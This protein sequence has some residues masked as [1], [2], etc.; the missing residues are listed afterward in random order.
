[1]KSAQIEAAWRTLATAAGRQPGAYTLSGEW[2]KTDARRDHVVRRY[3]GAHEAV[4]FKM[5]GKPADAKLFQ[6]LLEA[7]VRAAEGMAGADQSVPEV[8]EADLEARAFLMRAVAGRTVYDLLER[9][10]DPAECL[11]RGGRWIAAFHRAT[12]AETR[13]FQPKFMRNHIAHLL[14]QQAKGEISIA[15]PAAFRRHAE[16][17]IALAGQFEGRKTASA[18]THGDMNLRN[19]LLDGPR[20][21]GIDFSASH[22]APVGFDVARFLLHYVG[23]FAELE[24][25]PKGDVIAPDLLAAFFQGYDLVQADDPSVQYLLRVRLLMDW[26][27]LPSAAFDRSLPQ[28]RRLDR[29]LH[30]ADRTFA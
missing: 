14:E 3:D 21:H 27:S 4:V 22:N 15:Q 9:G 7:Q 24:A 26:A 6:S 10:G 5:V 2:R 19:I 16:V 30:L 1:M 12:F 8:L 20:G 18:A 29:L 11:E 28:R 13:T 17:A 25:V 23:V